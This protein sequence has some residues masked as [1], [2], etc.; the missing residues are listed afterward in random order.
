ML[1][2]NGEEEDMKMDGAFSTSGGI[3]AVLAACVSSSEAQRTCLGT[4]RESSFS[5]TS[6]KLQ[7]CFVS[8]LLPFPPK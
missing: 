7:R 2:A 8:E 3:C 1:K 5:P 6:I 4:C